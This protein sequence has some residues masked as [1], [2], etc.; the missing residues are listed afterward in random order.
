MLWLSE[1]KLDK[2]LTSIDNKSFLAEVTPY[3]V[4]EEHRLSKM[5]ENI[6]KGSTDPYQLENFSGDFLDILSGLVPV[7]AMFDLIIVKVSE[8]IL[9]QGY[10]R[11][12]RDNVARML[13][14]VLVSRAYTKARALPIPEQI[15]KEDSSLKRSYFLSNAIMNCGLFTHTNDPEVFLHALKG[16]G[17]KVSNYEKGESNDAKG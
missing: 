5:L 16:L 10:D 14:M 8:K 15:E 2:I 12:D 17:Y 7:R 6:Q 3:F 11:P 1:I 4:A 13:V 9:E